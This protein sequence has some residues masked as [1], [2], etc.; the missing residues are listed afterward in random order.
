[1]GK[2]ITNF[3]LHKVELIDGGLKVAYTETTLDEKGN[4]ESNDIATVF[5]RPPHADLTDVFYVGFS[6]TL[7][8]A[9]NISGEGRL[10][11]Y[12]ATFAG[13]N[14]NIGVSLTGILSGKD[15]GDVRIKT[16][17]LKYKIGESATS[18][19]LTVLCYQLNAEVQEYIYNGKGAD[20]IDFLE[21]E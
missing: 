14:D 21:G 17:R 7:A 6:H 12:A 11:V 18:N 4:E 16:K 10:V 19:K 3:Q 5:S 8:E 15:V 20:V 2:E 1:M 9:L 13:K